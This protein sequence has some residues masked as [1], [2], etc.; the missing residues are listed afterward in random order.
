MVLLFSSIFLILSCQL[1]QL[2]NC[3]R[4]SLFSGVAFQQRRNKLACELLKIITL[5]DW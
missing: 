5:M 2:G 1:G 3:F 4:G